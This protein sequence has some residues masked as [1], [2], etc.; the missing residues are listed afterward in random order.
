MDI[1]HIENLTK[2]LQCTDLLLQDLNHAQKD[3]YDDEPAL[4]IL[5][6]DL[7]RDAGVIKHRLAELEAAYR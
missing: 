6:R 7:I 5:L 1:K 3:A 4:S 2:A